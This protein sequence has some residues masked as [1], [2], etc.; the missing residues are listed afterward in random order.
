MGVQNTQAW[1]M[2]AALSSAR[3]PVAGAAPLLRAD[4]FELEAGP[5]EP[6]RLPDHCLLIPLQSEPARGVFHRAGQRNRV[7]LPPGGLIAAPAG[8]DFS[9]DWHGPV[10]LLMIRVDPDRI[11]SFVRGDLR[12]LAIGSHIDDGGVLTDTELHNWAL[13]MKTALAEPGLGQPVLFEAL[14][15]V[16]LV[17]LARRYLI[18]D[19]APVAETGGLTSQQYARLLEYID[20]RIH[21]TLRTPDMAQHLGM[22]DSALGRA[23]KQSAGVTPQALVM[24]RRLEVAKTQ[25]RR[26]GLSLG[27][28]ALATGFA[29]QAHLSRSF[30]AAE[31]MT[32][33]AY[34]KQAVSGPKLN[35]YP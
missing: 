8:A 5:L 33:S 9:C 24:Q 27:A 22:S 2:Q 15:R 1:Y 14:A 7:H 21:Q 4:Y 26:P 28:I 35:G 11:Q 3:L 34:R 20:G 31:G 19:G 17:T 10:S 13:Q 6:V 32:P 18:T 25:L 23:V 12:I 30:K 29:D 16:F